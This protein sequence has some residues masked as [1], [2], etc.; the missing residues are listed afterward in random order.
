MQQ[1]LIPSVFV[2]SALEKEFKIKINCTPQTIDQGYDDA[3]AARRINNYA[4][5]KGWKKLGDQ[6]V[7]GGRAIVYQR[8]QDTRQLAIGSV[9]ADSM[10]AILTCTSD[11]P[12]TSA[13]PPAKTAQGTR[14]SLAHTIY[15]RGAKV[16]ASTFCKTHGCKLS[17]VVREPETFF[18]AHNRE[19][20]GL[21]DGS[22][23]EVRRRDGS[24]MI[25]QINLIYKRGLSK[26]SAAALAKGLTEL[27]FGPQ[28]A[29]SVS[30]AAL[31]RCQTA[32]DYD[33]WIGK[34][35]ELYGFGV[36]CGMYTPGTVTSFVS[37]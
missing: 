17:R 23:L 20:Y 34:S 33:L 30:K 29:N 25:F 16:E 28:A 31:E 9:G 7:V 6:Q 18:P 8:S 11:K 3:D 32:E 21:R 13:S 26:A 4:A 2:T 36:K 37:I 1:A 10:Y 14:V 22:T 5:Q 19:I 24:G 27:S 35:K 15:G 12:L